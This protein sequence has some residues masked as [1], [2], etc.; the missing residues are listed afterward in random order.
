MGGRRR[1]IRRID[2][3]LPA[4]NGPYG[5]GRVARTLH[6]AIAVAI[7]VQLSVGYLMEGDESG[8]GRGRGRGGGSGHGRGRGGGYDPFGDDALLTLHVVLGGTILALAIIRLVWRL[9]TPL[10]PW[11]PGLSRVERTIVHWTELALYVLMIAIPLSGLWLV[12]ADDDDLVGAHVATHLAF[13][14]VIALHI[15]MVAKH[16]IVDRDQFLRRMLGRPRR[17]SAF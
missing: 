12:L 11:A 1:T 14:V 8:R 4:G 2:Q 13:F 3:R 17:G 7:A 6:W 10:P 16:Q 5:F 15:G 9:T